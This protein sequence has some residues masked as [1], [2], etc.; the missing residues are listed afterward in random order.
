MGLAEAVYAVTTAWPTFERFS[1]ID[2]VR[3]AAVSVP[4]NIAEGHGRTGNREFLHHCSVANGSI[5]EVETHLLLA[6]RLSYVDDSTAD[7]LLQ[8]TAETARVLQGFMR[9]LRSKAN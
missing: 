7:A 6:H 1:M 2:Q 8:Q 4:A 5:S 3:R 9:Y